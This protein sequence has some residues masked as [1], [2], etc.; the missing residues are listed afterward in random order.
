[1][2]L[3]TTYFQ[4]FFCSH[5]VL[6]RKGS[7]LQKAVVPECWLDPNKWCT[8]GLYKETTQAWPSNKEMLVLIL[9]DVAR[10]IDFLY[11]SFEKGSK[12]LGHQYS[13]TVSLNPSLIMACFSGNSAGQVLNDFLIR[14]FHQ[15]FFEAPSWGSFLPRCNQAA[16]SWNERATSQ[17]ASQYAYMCLW[18][19]VYHIFVMKYSI[20]HTTSRILTQL[21]KN[22]RTWGWSGRCHAH[23]CWG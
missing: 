4:P 17:K 14:Y 10:F 21:T 9:V 19:S 7:S 1:M 15:D 13:T 18:S 12:Q 8:S 6:V 22:I 3:Q 11:T 5:V 2:Y 23:Q 20:Y 16:G